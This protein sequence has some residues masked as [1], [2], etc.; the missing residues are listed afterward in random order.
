M[1]DRLSSDVALQAGPSLIS[2]LAS[3]NDGGL[4]WTPDSMPSDVPQP[5]FEGSVVSHR[6]AVLGDRL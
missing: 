5:V 4:T 1:P 3:T 2:A 6:F